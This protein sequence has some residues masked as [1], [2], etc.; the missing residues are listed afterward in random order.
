[1]EETTPEESKIMSF[2]MIAYVKLP[3]SFVHL[4]INFQLLK[5]FVIVYV[6][7]TILEILFIIRLINTFLLLKL[8]LNHL[9]F[10]FYKYFHC[11]L[12]ESIDILDTGQEKMQ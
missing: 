8:A 12:W 3:L 4:T 5:Y 10:Q 2:S 1:M 6:Y 11:T 9:K 7:F